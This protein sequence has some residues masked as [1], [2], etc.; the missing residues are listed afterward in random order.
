MSGVV[1]ALLCALS[2]AIGSVSMRNLSTKVDPFTLNAPRTLVGAI[3]MIVAM[4]ATGSQSGIAD[5]TLTKY[6]YMVIA[7]LVGA[8]IGDSL[9]VGSMS[10]IGVSLSFPISSTYPIITLMLSFFF[11]QE[12]LSITII[13]GLVLALVGLLLICRRDKSQ[14]ENAVPQKTGILMSFGAAILWAISAIIL[15]PGIEGIDAVVVSAIRMPVLSLFFWLVSIISGKV[16][17]L[18]KLSLRE[19]LTIV[20]GGLI[21]WGAGSILFVQ[22]VAMLGPTRAAIITSTSPLFALPMSILLLGEK[23]C[24]TVWIGTALTV[25]GIALVS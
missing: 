25:A 17:T 18:W 21:G 13:A 4:Y 6:A 16:G 3:S 19:W 7:L 20:F 10:R 24:R 15:K 2:W 11:L 22:A 5:V 9:Y 12:S 14:Q 23:P 1:I 8:G